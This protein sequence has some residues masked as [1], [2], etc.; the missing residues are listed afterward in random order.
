M[1][2]GLSWD[3]LGFVMVYYYY[4]KEIYTK[5]IYLVCRFFSMTTSRVRAVTCTDWAHL[6]LSTQTAS[7][8][9]E[10]TGTPP[11][12]TLAYNHLIMTQS[13][14]I[15]SITFYLFINL[16]IFW[17][18]QKLLNV[19]YFWFKLINYMNSIISF[20]FF[21][22]KISICYGNIYVIYYKFFLFFFDNW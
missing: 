18:N 8:R 7:K 22:K 1:S 6:F 5:N 13:L 12:T 2:F 4:K 17:I 3:Q 21:F 14:R 9:T 19:I 11:N 20:C 15:D 16:Y 10:K